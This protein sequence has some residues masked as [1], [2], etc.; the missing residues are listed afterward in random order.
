L[1]LLGEIIRNVLIINGIFG[2]TMFLAALSV[3][4]FG[5]TARANTD[6]RTR[7]P[8][9]K[10]L[11]GCEIVETVGE[12]DPPRRASKRAS[13][14]RRRRASEPAAPRLESGRREP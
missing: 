5:S 8:I 14:R 13:P 1:K 7:R 9:L 12:V 10:A 3:P 6:P 4:T 11:E 2:T